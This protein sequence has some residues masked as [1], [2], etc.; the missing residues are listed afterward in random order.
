MIGYEAHL[1][2]LASVSF[3][4]SLGFVLSSNWAGLPNLSLIACYGAGWYTFVLLSNAGLPV[5]GAAIVS[6]AASAS[7]GLAVGLGSQRLRQDHL[8]LF[9]LALATC[10]QVLATC[11]RSVTGG[12]EGQFLAGVPSADLPRIAFTAAVGFALAWTLLRRVRWGLLITAFRDDEDR[13]DGIVGVTVRIRACLGLAVGATAGVGGTLMAILLGYVDPSVL[14]LNTLTPVLLVSALVGNRL[15]LSVLAPAVAAV[16]LAPEAIRQLPLPT[17]RTGAS[18]QLLY[19]IP[20]A[21]VLIWR[22]HQERWY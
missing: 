5:P 11:A 7:L 16:T 17:F 2:T 15:A 21:T 18:E 20:V 22:S 1:V 3:I 14:S 4:L 10:M 6:V 13:L 19:L 12:P 8:A 9:T